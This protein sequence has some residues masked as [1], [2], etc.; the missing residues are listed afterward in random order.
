MNIRDDWNVAAARAQ[1]CDDVLEIRGVLD[2]R[3]GDAD[4]LATDG[5]EVERLLDRFG[6][7]HRVASQH[8]LHHDG[9]T[10]A[11]DDSATRWIPDDHLAG[12]APVIEK[13]RLA[14]THVSFS[15]AW[16]QI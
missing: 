16:E 15:Q 1:I 6:G 7:V 8:R 11:N 4:D 2:G 14:I 9:V 3:R 13:R 10:A 12:L 5:D